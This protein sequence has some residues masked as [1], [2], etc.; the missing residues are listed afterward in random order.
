MVMKNCLL[1][2]VFI[3]TLAATCLSAAC[4]ADNEQVRDRRFGGK[5]STWNGF[6]RCDFQCDSRKCIVVVPAAAAQGLPWIWRARFFGH[7]PQTD[8]A[9]LEKGFHLVYMDVAGLYGSPKAVEHFK[10]FKSRVPATGKMELINK[11]KRKK[12]K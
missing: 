12:R 6:E 5:R 2:S 8:I 1:K 3:L 4:A 9:L 7:E 11:A 10:D